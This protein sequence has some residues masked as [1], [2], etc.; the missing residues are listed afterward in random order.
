MARLGTWAAF[1]GVVAGGWNVWAHYQV[2]TGLCPAWSPAPEGIYGTVVLGLAI[3]LVLCSLTTLMAPSFV[4]YISSAICLL[5]DA[6]LA[7]DY[8]AI[9]P[10]PLYVTFILVT[11]SLVLSLISAV[12]KTSVSEQSNP[13]NLPVFG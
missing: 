10:G 11:L 1:V 4:F 3:V 13:M 5:I 8:S 9:A 6:V 7:L 2:C 12:R